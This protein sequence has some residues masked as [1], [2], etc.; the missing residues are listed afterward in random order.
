MFNFKVTGDG[1]TPGMTRFNSDQTKRI[2][3]FMLNACRL[4]Q[5]GA[6]KKLTWKNFTFYNGRVV[7][8]KGGGRASGHLANSITY[9]IET[10]GQ[11]TIIGRVGTNVKYAPEVEGYPAK[12]K[13]E[14]ITFAES[15]ALR[16]WAVRHGFDV[17]KKTGLWVGPGSSTPF[18]LPT[19]KEKRAEIK[20]NLER[21]CKI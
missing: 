10:A 15:P 1:I 14:F 3:S 20:L 13:K 12:R 19:L 11:D 16:L 6:Q 4:L 17:E 9:E 21:A 18:L 8:V 7:G 5:S 2:K